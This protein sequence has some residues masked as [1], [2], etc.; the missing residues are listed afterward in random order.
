M[1]Y[2]DESVDEWVVARIAH[3]EPVRAQPDDVDV[4]IT[5]N[6]TTKPHVCSS[7]HQL[8]QMDIFA[9]DL[10]LRVHGLIYFIQL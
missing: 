1:T 10:K 8:A 9:F 6:K 5:E 4:T 3:G 7:A 2:V